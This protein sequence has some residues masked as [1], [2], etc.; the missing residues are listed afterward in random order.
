MFVEGYEENELLTIL[1]DEEAITNKIESFIEIT[2]RKTK[3]QQTK[4]SAKLKVNLV[5]L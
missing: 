5:N 2:Q 4:S 1:Q 3:C